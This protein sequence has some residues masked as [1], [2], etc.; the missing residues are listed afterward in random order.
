M[1]ARAGGI[2]LSSSG[3]TNVDM[4]ARAGGIFLSSSGNTNVDMLARAGGIFLSSSC[5]TDFDTVPFLI[6]MLVLEVL[7]VV[8]LNVEGS[9]TRSTVMA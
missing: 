3:I 6:G 5:I 9:L 4:L 2:F 1:L 7:R 8:R